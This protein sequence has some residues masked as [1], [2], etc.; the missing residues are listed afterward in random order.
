MN[1][2]MMA[3]PVAAA[4][5]L[6]SQP[7][8]AGGKG[9]KQWSPGPPGPGP[10]IEIP[11]LAGGEVKMPWVEFAKILEALKKDK[12]PEHPPVDF[13]VEEA[14]YA[15]RV[16]GK[17]EVAAVDATFSVRVMR[18]GWTTVRLLSG[19][20]AVESFKASGAKVSLSQSYGQVS[21]VVQG[22]ASFEVAMKLS[23]SVGSEHGMKTLWIDGP[24]AVSARLECTI[25]GK[26]LKVKVEP[27][28]ID[29][30][31]TQDGKV[32]LTASLFGSGSFNLKWWQ[33]V[34]I[35]DS[36]KKELPPKVYGEVN[37]LIRVGE[38]LVR[39]HAW[40]DYSILQSGIQELKILVPEDISI[41]DVTGS[42]LASWE[43]RDTDSGKVLH[44]F[45][46]YKVKNGYTLSIAYDMSM[47]KTSAV[48]EVPRLRLLDVEREKGTY[49]V[50]VLTN[51]EVNLEKMSG[52]A[53]IDAAELPSS[54]TYTAQHPV[55]LAFK[56]LKH[57]Y[58]LV[59]DVKK[60]A[61]VPI[62]VATVD[63]ADFTTLVTADGK[64]LTR[65]VLSMRNNMKQFL[66]AK[67][68][69]DSEVWSSF[70]AGKPVKPGQDDEGRI[71]IPLAKST[72]GMSSENFP[73]ELIYL[74]RA[75]P[76]GIKG[77][78]GITLCTVDLPITHLQWS[79]FLPD[80]YKYKKFDGNVD[81][82]DGAFKHVSQAVP[83]DAYAIIEEAQVQMNVDMRN[84]MI[85][86]QL[87][88]SIAPAQSM[89]KGVLPVKMS[90]PEQGKLRRFI[91]LLVI[92]EAAKITF[93]Y[94]LPWKYR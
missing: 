27:G 36:E 69:E 70:V 23:R 43:V 29:T 94:K 1:K 68:P 85:M 89:S 38:G 47:G 49:G 10:G 7:A 87:A 20:V 19:D 41:I 31:E 13:A 32:K 84:E 66:K 16:D 4:L 67:L 9:S 83:D 91:K 79:L 74:T 48:V 39:G 54:I 64:V 5:L 8:G 86:D 6:A 62:L 33:E 71:L 88:Q 92:D 3:I 65:V 72:P 44:A 18:E 77:K 12:A 81:E 73:V 45:L 52:M 50:E 75:K 82:W 55:L 90:V 46:N 34:Q 24:E 22:P 14:V 30:Q 51:V 63:V 93:K 56:Y 53:Q 17:G 26:G 11:P 60:H 35:P 25:A 15:C 59:L 80:K 57:P 28:I 21:A 76:L 61:D 58:S 2:T 42:D 37:T 78:G 40:V